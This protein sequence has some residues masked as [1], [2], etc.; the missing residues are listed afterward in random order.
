MFD[1]A[2]ATC[3]FPVY[4]ITKFKNMKT[5]QVKI[6]IL[7]NFYPPDDVRTCCCA[8]QLASAFG[9]PVAST[10]GFRKKKYKHKSIFYKFSPF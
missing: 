5:T 10:G 9:C 3:R 7:F 4:G 6:T 2:E 1:G 8:K